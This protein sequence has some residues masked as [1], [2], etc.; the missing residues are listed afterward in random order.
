[1]NPTSSYLA[2]TEKLYENNENG[3]IYE[4]DATVLD[5]FAE[6]DGY[7]VELDRTAFFPCEGGQG[8]DRGILGGAH[9]LD[10]ILEGDELLHRLDAPLAVGATVTGEVDAVRRRRHMQVHT[11]EHIL[12]GIASTLFGCHNV[13]FHIGSED[14][15]VDYD[16]PLTE[17]QIRDLERRTNK[18]IYENRTVRAY[19]PK[20]ETLASISYRYLLLIL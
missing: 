15:T 9:V 18:A 13:G 20:Q 10:V 2:R 8:A 3:Y 4:F 12:S 16:M 17:A 11:G 14:M 1:M 19:Y 7:F 6:G 5:C